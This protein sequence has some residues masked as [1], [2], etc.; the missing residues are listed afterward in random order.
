MHTEIKTF[1]DACA[2]LQLNPETVLPDLI[3]FPSQHQ[4]ALLSHA[5]LV[6]IAEAVNDGWKPNWDDED[7]YKYYPWFDM[8]KG[9][10]FYSFDY[11]GQGSNVGSRLCFRSRE[12]AM[13]VGKQFKGLY[14]DYFV[15]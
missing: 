10:V 3:G 6:I 4:K 5:K 2:K 1:E 7:E 11:D 14:K 15:L 9:F 12:I 8:E 13:Y